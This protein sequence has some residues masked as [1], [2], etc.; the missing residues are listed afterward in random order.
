MAQFA[1]VCIGDVCTRILMRIRAYHK[2]VTVLDD[3]NICTHGPIR[4]RAYH[5]HV[6]V[7]DEAV[8]GNVHVDA[9]IRLYA[10]VFYM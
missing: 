8:C 7:L 5:K 6:T 2:H 9:Y 4:I 10:H 3:Q 1:K